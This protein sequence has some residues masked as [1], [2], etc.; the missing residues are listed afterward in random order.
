[1]IPSKPLLITATAL[2]LLTYFLFHE[3]QKL[4][5]GRL[6]IYIM[7]IGQGDSSLIVTPSG[8]QIIIDG[9]RDGATL[10]ELPRHISFFDRTIDLL[11]LTHPEL[12]HIAAFPEILRRYKVGGVLMTGVQAGLPLYTDFLTLIK[13][14]KIPIYIADPAKDLDMGDG[15]VLDVVWPKPTLFGQKYGDKLNDTSV[16]FRLMRNGEPFAL[17][18]GDLEEKG[19]NELLQTGADLRA[20]LLK[21]GHHGSKTSSSTGFLLAVSPKEVGISAGKDN[22]YGHPHAMVTGRYQKFGIPYRLTATE[23]TLTFRY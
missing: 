22:S 23:G 8:K 11:V 7:D 17:F 21:A 5:D 10:A 12:D 3:Y 1:M 18:T 6:H 16:V 20:P 2:S 19:E 13:E 15:V 9:G 14:Q 4:P